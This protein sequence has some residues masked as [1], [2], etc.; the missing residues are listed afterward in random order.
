MRNIVT[1]GGSKLA[2]IYQT[3]GEFEKALLIL[4]QGGSAS[5][6]FFTFVPGEQATESFEVTAG[7]NIQLNDPG[8]GCHFKFI[9][10]SNSSDTSSDG[11]LAVE[12][13]DY[14]LYWDNVASKY[15]LTN[16]A[17]TTKYFFVYYTFCNDAF[18]LPFTSESLNPSGAFV[19][20]N[21]LSSSR[22][23]GVGEAGNK[24]ADGNFD[25]ELDFI[26]IPWLFYTVL[27]KMDLAKTTTYNVKI[28]RSNS[29][30]PVFNVFVSHGGS[31][32]TV[33][34]NC[35]ANSLRFSMASDAI[36]GITLDVI[37]MQ[38]LTGSYP[39]SLSRDL[40]SVTPSFI[41]PG[42]FS[43]TSLITI[44]Y[45]SDDVSI[46]IG[47]YL[48]SLE[49][50]ISNNLGTDL[51]KIAGDQRIA[52]P[53]GEFAIS[54]TIEFLIPIGD[55]VGD[56]HVLVK[57]I[58][59]SLDVGSLIP[60][61]LLIYT[62]LPKIFRIIMNNLQVTGVSHDISDRGILK[63]SVDFVGYDDGVNEMITVEAD[64]N[65]SSFIKPFVPTSS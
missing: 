3:P 4:A 21:S 54:G 51:Y 57:D 59:L 33:F 49:F 36:A 39:S 11:V 25:T 26:A 60:E 48:S 41:F 32:N 1:G 31:L 19:N 22:I 38:Y 46:S 16:L 56:N 45:A 15:I 53:E 42:K 20:S 13:Q 5:D 8:D 47:D 62:A 61:L 50:T 64:I 9:V 23:K 10:A 24:A 44:N 43:D 14:S 28:T 65:S 58:F 34:K 63:L 35:K 55:V 40:G 7:G 27:G 52:V 30:L 2:L 29:F 12:G 18:E 37:G 17:S 6:Y